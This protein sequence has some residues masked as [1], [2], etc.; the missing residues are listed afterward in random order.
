MNTIRKVLKI[1]VLSTF[2]I[3]CS[4]NTKFKIDN[5]I[6][7]NSYEEALNSLCDAHNND[8]N[9][10]PKYKESIEQII[11]NY[12]IK[13]VEIYLKSNE[14]KKIEDLLSYFAEKR[15]TTDYPFLLNLEDQVSLFVSDKYYDQFSEANQRGD[16]ESAIN[17]LEKAIIFRQ[18]KEH[19][20]LANEI[21]RTKISI[22]QLIDRIGHINWNNVSEFSQDIDAFLNYKSIQN[23][24]NYLSN[25]IPYY[26]YKLFDSLSL[27]WNKDI[28]IEKKFILSRQILMDCSLTESKR[29][30]LWNILFKQYYDMISRKDFIDKKSNRLFILQMNIEDGAKYFKPELDSYYQQSKIS[31]ID[32][33]ELSLGAFEKHS[34]YDTILSKKVNQLFERGITLIS[35][36]NE[37]IGNSIINSIKMKS[38]NIVERDKNIRFNINV[39]HF[40]ISI[41]L[42]K[43]NNPISSKYFNG[44]ISVS[45]PEYEDLY[46]N[47]LEAKRKYERAKFAYEMGS[48]SNF[49]AMLK[50]TYAK[51]CLN[52]LEVISDDLDNTPSTISKKDYVDYYLYETSYYLEAELVATV[53][54]T[55]FEKTFTKK[56][57]RML[58]TYRGIHD[59]DINK[60]N[61]KSANIPNKFVVKNILINS[62]ADDIYY[63]IL[64]KVPYLLP[65]DKFASKFLNQYEL[66][67]SI[68]FSDLSKQ[69]ISLVL[70]QGNRARNTDIDNNK[71]ILNSVAKSKNENI[72]KYL[73]NSSCQIVSYSVNYS[74]ST[75]TG[76]FIS[77]DG[78]IITNA[79]VVEGYDNFSALFNKGG[80]VFT[81]NCKRIKIDQTLDLALLKLEKPFDGFEAIVLSD[82]VNIELGDEIIYVG[83]PS[84]PLDIDANPFTSRGY[85]SQVYHSSG[86]PTL[87]LL[88]I[89]ANQGA[90]GSAIVN[91]HTGELLGTLTWGFG[92]SITGNDIFRII[93]GKSINIKESQNVATTV[94]VLLDFLN[95]K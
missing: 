61:Y 89:T 12:Y 81:R 3:S 36:N 57:N 20:D 51:K 16:L 2:L 67:N 42:K 8:V 48:S 22:D 6:L 40:T 64:Q 84:T 30:S 58:Y 55:E 13:S 72:I 19:I 17:H 93:E 66:E 21:S 85:I 37:D 87:I 29:K 92:R 76:Y 49:D 62:I 90:S 23:Y 45:N 56:I 79:H 7:N 47:F 27:L 5:D 14:E 53:N 86:T 80:E 59:D 31:D 71:I 38:D 39:N 95:V 50:L 65:N 70:A 28:E 4:F 75:G 69:K 94:N 35:T 54:S 74:Y 11:L 46:Y 24:N 25:N 9:L 33:I 34:S 73:N 60:S 32:L 41:E 44:Y 82:N 18:K 77:E 26:S 43:E 52:E 91:L 63:Q 68:K 83:Y 78:Y 88:D 1:M 10:N 15:Q